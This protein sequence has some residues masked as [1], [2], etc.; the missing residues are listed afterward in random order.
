MSNSSSSIIGLCCIVI[1]VIAFLVWV[2][3]KLFKPKTPQAQP[4][5]SNQVQN[6]MPSLLPENQLSN[7]VKA[8]KQTPPADADRFRQI[9]PGTKARWAAYGS[10]AG[11]GC[12]RRADANGA[13]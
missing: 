6:Q 8:K 3:F 9:S 5:I 7:S 10:L 4:L 13:A 12:G 11:W 1:P 2:G